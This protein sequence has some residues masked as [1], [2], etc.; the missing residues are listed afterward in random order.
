MCIFGNL[1]SFADPLP[2]LTPLPIWAA[3]RQGGSPQI[4][5]NP[6]CFREGVVATLN[7]IW[8]SVTCVS[9]LQ[10]LAWVCSSPQPSLK[11][12][13]F[14]SS[15]YSTPHPV[16]IQ[17]P[18]FFSILPHFLLPHLLHI[19]GPAMYCL[20]CWRCLPTPTQVG[21]RLGIYSLVLLGG[22]SGESPPTASSRL[23]PLTSAA[24]SAPPSMGF[25]PSCRIGCLW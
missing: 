19:P 25:Y 23:F 16:P 8:A 11:C 20:C 15:T 5:D 24:A 2:F 14:I 10:L 4:S 13:P 1:S 6:K 12:P 18:L 17:F 7:H 21:L 9:L 22:E 3:F